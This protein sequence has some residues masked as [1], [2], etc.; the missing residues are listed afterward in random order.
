M[1]SMH[2]IQISGR[3]LLITGLA[4]AVVSCSGTAELS[5]EPAPF[6]LDRELLTDPL[7][8]PD[9]NLQFS[10]PVGFA[11]I[12]SLRLDAFR[13]MQAGTALTREFYPL[14]THVVFA[15]SVSGAIIYAARLEGTEGA[16]APLAKQYRDFLLSRMDASMLQEHYYLI[17][18]IRICHY[19]HHTSE[20]VNHKLLGETT[21]G[22]R[23]LIEYV[24][25]ATA[26]PGLEPAVHS[27]MAA[28]R[29]GDV[30]DT[31]SGPEL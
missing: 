15:D 3:L 8:L 29:I 20:I 21:P 26:N 5:F 31:T 9:L 18:D 12:D 24:I 22:K 6:T 10:P 13:R 23:F 14:L 7:Y 4:L 17:N 28:L 16:L 27:S 2:A 11:A 25:P 1:R 30:Q 19:L